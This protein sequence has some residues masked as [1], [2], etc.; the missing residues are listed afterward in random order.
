ML[1]RDSGGATEIEAERAAVHLRAQAVMAEILERGSGGSI[2]A[3]N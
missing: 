1:F 3:S 2:P